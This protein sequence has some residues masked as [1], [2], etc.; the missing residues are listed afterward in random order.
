M[1][2]ADHGSK[3]TVER[4]KA[5]YYGGL[6]AKLEPENK[7]RFVAVDVD[8]RDYE[9]ADTVLDAVHKLRARHPGVVP[10]IHR[11]GYSAAYA[12]G[13]G[14]REDGAKSPTE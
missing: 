2:D 13:G 5:I 4:G 12:F 9:V 7:R 6:R 8:T 1:S 10:Y 11:A 14:L 3:I